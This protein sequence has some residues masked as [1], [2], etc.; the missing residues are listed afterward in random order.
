ML[1]LIILLLGSIEIVIFFFFY[2][3]FIF[4]GTVYVAAIEMLL[5]YHIKITF[6]FMN[7]TY[8]SKLS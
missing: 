3:C 5:V 4:R 6:H 1:L 7:I 2:V 8:R